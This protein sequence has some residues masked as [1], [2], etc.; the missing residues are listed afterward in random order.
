MLVLMSYDVV[1][2]KHQRFLSFSFF[3]VDF[4]HK[5]LFSRK[6]VNNKLRLRSIV[7]F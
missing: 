4:L 2:D 1:G 3:F 6:R 7:I 5:S